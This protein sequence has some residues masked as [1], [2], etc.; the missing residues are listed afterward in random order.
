MMHL[1]RAPKG[2]VLAHL[3]VADTL[4]TRT[5]GLLGRDSLGPDQGL[6]IKPCNSVH[7]FFMKF[8]IDL[9]F[10]DRELKVRRLYEAVP[11]NRVVL[12]M[13]AHSVIELPAGFLTNN[14]FN[15]GERVYVDRP[16]S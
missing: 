11:P 1:K 12:P 14:H 4:W 13:L 8:P 9:I 7:T 6:W 16:L 15:L 5:R 10:L 2:G 3:D